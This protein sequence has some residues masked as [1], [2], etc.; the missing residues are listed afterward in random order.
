[1]LP[2]ELSFRNGE[3]KFQNPLLPHAQEY[4][5]MFYRYTHHLSNQL[6]VVVTGLEPAI[7]K[8]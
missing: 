3:T 8:E 4:V 7:S 1:M 5:G 6:I 2:S